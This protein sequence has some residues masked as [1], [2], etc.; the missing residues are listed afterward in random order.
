MCVIDFMVSIVGNSGFITT[1]FFKGT[2]LL[3]IRK[4]LYMVCKIY[5]GNFNFQQIPFNAK[6]IAKYRKWDYD[7]LCLSRQMLI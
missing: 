5:Q 7:R 2:F 1:V 3:I 4:Y 6:P